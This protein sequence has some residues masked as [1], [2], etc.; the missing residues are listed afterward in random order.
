MHIRVLLVQV[1]QLHR[2]RRLRRRAPENRQPVVAHRQRG[3][4]PMPCLP[5]AQTLHA[6]EA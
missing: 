4:M 6:A 2:V 1:P 5:T 3:Q